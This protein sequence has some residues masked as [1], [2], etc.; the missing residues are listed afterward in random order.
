MLNALNALWLVCKEEREGHEGIGP[1]G[2]DLMTPL[3]EGLMMALLSRT[4]IREFEA[5]VEKLE[6]KE[7]EDIEKDDM[8]DWTEEWLE[9]NRHASE[10]L[11]QINADFFADNMG[12]GWAS[13][14]RP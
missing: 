11:A 2:Y 10:W 7:Q 8:P 9:E 6:K 3:N 12:F 1:V 5:E 4:Y 13:L 14:S